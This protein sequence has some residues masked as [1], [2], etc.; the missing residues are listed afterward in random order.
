MF[1]DTYQTKVLRVQ[2]L[3]IGSHIL[4]VKWKL[5]FMIIGEVL[6]NIQNKILHSIDFTNVLVSVLSIFTKIL[7]VHTHDL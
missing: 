3:E 5:F 6:R 7:T 4:L 1:T 2:Y